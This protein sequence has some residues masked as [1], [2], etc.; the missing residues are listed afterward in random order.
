MVKVR[1]IFYGISGLSFLLVG[2]FIIARCPQRLQVKCWKPNL[3]T[4]KIC[5]YGVY[6]IPTISR[7]SCSSEKINHTVCENVTTSI[8]SSS[9]KFSEFIIDPTGSYIHS[10]RY[11]SN[12]GKVDISQ[13]VIVNYKTKASL[14]IPHRTGRSPSEL[15]KD[16][17]LFLKDKNQQH[18]QVVDVSLS[19]SW[20]LVIPAVILPIGGSLAFFRELCKS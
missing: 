19:E 13:L 16:L 9:L 20:F 1:K 15:K 3:K 7:V 12:G 6:E 4:D 5:R 11:R 10:G 2:L 17:D 14:Q 18:I 8:L